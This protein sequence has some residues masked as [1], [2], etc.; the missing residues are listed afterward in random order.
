M[1]YEV[2]VRKSKFHKTGGTIQTLVLHQI[3]K[4]VACYLGV[5]LSIMDHKSI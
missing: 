1:C 3:L 5:Y 4:D 2:S